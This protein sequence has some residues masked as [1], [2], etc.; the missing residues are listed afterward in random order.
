MTEIAFSDIILIHIEQSL[1]L[2]VYL[3]IARPYSNI[4]HTSAQIMHI[5]HIKHRCFMIISCLQILL[6]DCTN[7]SKQYQTIGKGWTHQPF[8][9]AYSKWFAPRKL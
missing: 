9:T 3:Q 4:I 6:W 1:A 2:Y 8:P 5:K 7:M